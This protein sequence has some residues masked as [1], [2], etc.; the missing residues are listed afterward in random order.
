M[1]ENTDIFYTYAY[2]RKKDRTP[3]YIGKGSNGRAYAKHG[4]IPVPKDRSRILFLKQNL[5][6][7]DA[8]KHE[9]YMISVF[10]R[11]DLGSGILLNRTNGGEGSVGTIMSEESRKRMSEAKQQMSEK[12]KQQMSEAKKGKNNPNYGRKLREETRRK[13][14]EAKRGKKRK[15]RTEEH[16]RK[17]SEARMGVKRGPYK[18]RTMPVNEL[19]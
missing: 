7:G 18:K 3:Y 4:Y 15:P 1:T 12:T 11:K 13:I 14:S 17:I 10:G 8:F 19:A 9:C 5:I 6:E 2:L 16:S